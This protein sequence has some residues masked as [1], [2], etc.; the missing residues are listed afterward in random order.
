M[1]RAAKSNVLLCA[2]ALFLAILVAPA[3]G[4]FGLKAFDS[5]FLNADE[6]PATLAGTHPFAQVTALAFNTVPVPGGDPSALPDGDVKDLAVSLPPGFVGDPTAVTTCTNVQF[7]EEACPASSRVGTTEATATAPDQ[8][9]E[10]P[11]YSLVPPP[12]QVVRLGFHVVRVPVT[13]DLKVNPDPPFNVLAGLHYTSN[14]VP[15]YASKLIIPGVQPGAA[16][17]FLTLP[18]AC[19]GP[20]PT[21]YEANSWQAPGSPVFGEAPPITITGCEAL[22]FGPTIAA[23]PTSSAAESPSGID[24]DLDVQDP[25]LTE[26][27]GTADSDIKKTVVTLPAGITTNPAIASGLEVCS[28]AQFQAEG[29]IDTDPATGCP[30]ASKV[31]RVSATT[32][33][34]DET[35]QGSVYVA[36][37]SDNP[38]N[39]LLAI[40]VV[41]KNPNLGISV[42]LAGKVEPDPDTGRLTTT[43]D[44]MPQ[45]PIGHLNF[46]FQGGSRAP[47]I[48][49]PTC[50]AYEGTVDLFPYSNPAAPLRRTVSFQ[51]DSPA[52][53]SGPCPTSASQQPHSPG[54]S[55]GTVSSKAGSYSPFFFKLDRADG[56]QRLSA[57]S[58]TLPKGLIAR[59]AG[60]PYCSEAQIAQASSRSGEGQ[61]ALELASP[62]C[63]SASRI[64]AVNAG[65]GAGPTPYFVNGSAYLAGPYKG[66]PLSVEIITPAL[67]GPFDLGVVAVRT[68]LYLD[69]ETAIVKAV[70]DPLPQILHGLPLDVRSV[71]VKMDRPS[72]TLNP[73]GC[74]PNAVTGTATSTLGTIAPLSSYFQ[75]SECGALGFKP[76][77]SLALK[78]GTKR[79][80]HP[81]LHSTLTYPQGGAYSNIAK[82]V[83]TLPP[84]EFIDNAHIQN[85]CTRVQFNAHQC[86]K[87]SILGKAKA[88]SP[89]LDAPLEGPVYFRSNGGDRLLPDIV[90]DLSGQIHVTLVGF[91]DSKK[92]RL[93]T[94]FQNV[95]DAPVTKFTLDLNGGKKGLLVNSANLCAKKRKAKL[96]LTAQNAIQ[97]NSEPVI[98][99]SCKKGKHKK[100][101]KGHKPKK[102]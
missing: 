33:L 28:L 19:T 78:G 84:T 22:G 77:L 75:A 63:P 8:I 91:V 12:G 35:L 9:F 45:F 14:A 68:A 56:S 6:T 82:A 67:A 74:D 58:T 101:S 76:K 36:K 73:T 25:G 49:P 99:T 51:I 60:I 39:S 64:G 71:S 87:G 44:D 66:A 57:V 95:P 62:S 97:L 72:F 15:I 48:T 98:K 93:R 90:A 46:H 50:G 53:G 10:V 54:F 94:T 17:P 52:G 34:L 13:I 40:Y 59:L 41:V 86:P 20:L 43:F 37:Q 47:L 42:R 69:P 55:A 83:V 79:N 1:S 2:T 100:G 85:P 27:G 3:Q 30:E 38:F 24:V 96:A 21:R 102:G 16:K 32:P 89:L 18:R 70:S 81:A 61:G 5:G 31:G 23:K 65:A 88:T 26:I 92:A 80:D 11:L 4:A 7:S 29:P